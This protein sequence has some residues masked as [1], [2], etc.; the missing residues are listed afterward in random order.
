MLHL[1]WL[2]PALP[3]LGFLI[4]AL[5]GK[6]LP[7][8]FQ[9]IV[10]AGTI[11]IAAI[12]VFI[13][14]AELLNLPVNRQI[15]NQTLWTWFSIEGFAPCIAFHLD[16]LSLVFIF[17]ITF[18]GFLIHVYSAEYMC[19]EEGYSRFFAYMNLL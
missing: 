4:L 3:F 19:H 13:L 14:G 18:V 10:G 8:K 16:T 2:I 15:F 7:K 1:L 17:V 5:F 11:G 6:F 9:A 12:L